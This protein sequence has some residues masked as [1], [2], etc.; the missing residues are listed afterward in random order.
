MRSFPL[1]KQVFAVLIVLLCFISVSVLSAQDLEKKD[2][3]KRII[4]ILQANLGARSEEAGNAKRRLVGQVRIVDGDTKISCDSAIHYIT[5]GRL[6]AYGTIQIV[7]KNRR[8]FSDFMTYDLSSDL[9]TFS[10]RVL[11]VE[12]STVILTT[13]MEYLSDS[14]EAIFKA[15]FQLF[16]KESTLYANRGK[17][18]RAQDSA[19]VSGNVQSEN[20]DGMLTTDSLVISKKNG[21]S[22]AIGSVFFKDSDQLNLMQSDTLFADSVGYRLAKGNVFTIKIDSAN[23]DTMA[24]WANQI[25]IIPTKLDNEKNDLLAI[26]Q[27]KQWS[28][29]IAAVS[30][31][32]LYSEELDSLSWISNPII[33]QED[34]ELSARA[35][36]LKMINGKAKTLYAMSAAQHISFDSLSNRFNQLAAERIEVQFDSTTSNITIMQA[37]GNAEVIYQSTDGSGKADG[38]VKMA[39]KQIQIHFDNDG[40][41]EDVTSLVDITGNYFEEEASLKD[42]KLEGFAWRIDSKPER[43]FIQPRESLKHLWIDSEYRLFTYPYEWKLPEDLSYIW[44]PENYK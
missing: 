43:P 21:R 18:Y 30:D 36:H 31:T 41:A 42:L 20:N 11:M 17:Y 34:S 9:S 37:V 15:D 13:E 25:E 35:I 8:I 12:D 33:W 14:E 7:E 28:K 27:V 10:G 5:E 29:S 23:A 22:Y 40:N 3:E 24:V 19:I 4:Q 39:A 16:D 6:E 1:L 2:I 38:L 26:G 44:F 32:L